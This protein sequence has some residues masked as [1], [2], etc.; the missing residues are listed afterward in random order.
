MHMHMHMRM[1]LTN[2][3]IFFICIQQHTSFWVT[4]RE[5]LLWC[6][7]SRW[8][9][10]PSKRAQQSEVQLRRSVTTQARAGDDTGK[11]VVEGEDNEAEEEADLAKAL[12]MA[13]S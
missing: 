7:D 12:T 6:V 4:S 5:L 3:H 11:G 2:S 9:C 8:K 1:L 13:H 10:V